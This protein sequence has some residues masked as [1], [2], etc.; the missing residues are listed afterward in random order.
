MV[1]LLDGFL[2]QATIKKNEL[3]LVGL[4]ALLLASKYEDFWHPR[5]KINMFKSH[6]HKFCFNAINV[7][8]STW[9]SEFYPPYNTGQ[10]L[11]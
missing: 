6:A 2:S 9:L 1:T 7:F 5:V 10:G 11:N 3:Q 4:T 8:Q